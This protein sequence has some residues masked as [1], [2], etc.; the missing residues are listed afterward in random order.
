MSHIHWV[1]RQNKLEI[2]RDKDE[3]NKWEIHECDGRTYDPDMIVVQ[4]T[5]KTTLKTQVLVRTPPTIVSCREKKEFIF[6]SI[7]RRR[8]SSEEVT[9][10]TLLLSEWYFWNLKKSRK[11]RSEN[12]DPRTNPN[13]DETPTVPQSHI[14][15]SLLFIINR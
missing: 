3:V 7:K 8:H 11:D 14:L 9:N 4:L 13:I 5:P 6:K 12:S 15:E 2:P 1:E 10:V